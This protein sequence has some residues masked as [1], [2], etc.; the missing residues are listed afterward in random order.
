MTFV[1]ATLIA[2]AIPVAF[3]AMIQII[4]RFSNR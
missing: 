1:E 4:D 2:L 3:I